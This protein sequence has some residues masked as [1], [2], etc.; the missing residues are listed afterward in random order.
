MEF[1][2]FKEMISVIRSEQQRRASLLNDQDPSAIDQWMY[3]DRPFVNELCLI[4]LVALWHQVEREVVGLAARA[5][6]D[7]AKISRQQYEGNRE[8]VQDILRS[9]KKGWKAIG[10]KLEL[11]SCDGYGPLKDVLRLLANSYKHDPSTRAVQKLLKNL[12]LDTTL[13]YASL[14]ES[15]GVREGFATL[16]GLGKD[17]DY[18]DIA[19]KFVDIANIF[20][21]CVA[22]KNRTRL[23][24]V[25]PN[26]VSFLP[27]DFLH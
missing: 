15:D 18:C 26:R 23:S 10:A 8:K 13:K 2:S 6:D 22:E 14:P 27:K 17:A 16:I 4:L 20:L 7:T 25:I 24:Q 1:G 21:V 3:E 12:S 11:Q 5:W 9:E 19:E